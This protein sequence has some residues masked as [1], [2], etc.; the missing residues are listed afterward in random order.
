MARAVA[1]LGTS[2]AGRREGGVPARP[3]LPSGAAGDSLSLSRLLYLMSKA[4]N[5][6]GPPVWRAM[7]AS[8]VR[9]LAP[10]VTQLPVQ[11]SA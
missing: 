10:P 5:R 8:A 11:P 4:A 6:R 9:V 1:A 3:P 7:V 2:E